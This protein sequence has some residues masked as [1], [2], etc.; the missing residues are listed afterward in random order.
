MDGYEFGWIPL[1]DPD[2]E[3]GRELVVVAGPQPGA[4]TVITQE[5]AARFVSVHQQLLH[6]EARASA[7]EHLL[8]NVP[9]V[10]PASLDH[11]DERGVVRVGSRVEAGDMLVGKVRVD[12]LGTHF[13]AS[14]RVSPHA[15]GTVSRA[16][17]ETLDNGSRVRVTVEL[18]QL[19]SLAIGDVLATA[20]ETRCVV[21]EIGGSLGGAD[22]R[23][24]GVAGR[25]RVGKLACADARLH[26]RS[27]GPYSL[28]TQRPIN[29]GQRV[30]EA[31][32]CALQARGAWWTAAELL[33]VK[34]GDITG[35]ENL[36]NSVVAGTPRCESTV[37][38]LVDALW[39]ELEAMGF[40]VTSVGTTERSKLQCDDRLRISLRTSNEIR[41]RSYGQVKYQ[42][43]VDN[44]THQPVPDGLFCERIFGP[45]ADFRC[46]C[47]ERAET[48]PRGSRCLQCGV[49]RI[50]SRAR[51]ERFGHIVL[52]SPVLH[53][54]MRGAVALLL[55]VGKSVIDDV[56]D[57]GKTLQGTDAMVAAE[58][59][60]SALGA[61][62]SA[63]NLASLAYEAGP[64][65]DLARAMQAGGTSPGALVLDVW[66]V[67]PPDL[68]PLVLLDGGR[69][70]TSDVT[71]L[72]LTL[73]RDNQRLDRMRALGT[74]PEEMVFFAER[75]LQYTVDALVQN[76]VSENSVWDEDA[77][78]GRLLVSLL[79]LS[80]DHFR[81]N[82]RGRT[83]DY[84]GTAVAV[85]VSSVGDDR[86]RLPRIMARE[87]FK[88]WI[89][90]E[91]GRRRL[92]STL[93]EA[94]AMVSARQ[95][96]AEAILARLV[97]G[98][99]VAVFPHRPEEIQP[100]I[101]VV[102][103]LVE[104]W[105]QPAVGISSS[106]AEALGIR[107]DGDAVVVHVPVDLRAV[108]EMLDLGSTAPPAAPSTGVLH[109]R[110]W[111][112]VVRIEACGSSHEGIASCVAVGAPCA[113]CSGMPVGTAIGLRAA[114]ALAPYEQSVLAAKTVSELGAL[115]ADPRYVATAF[116]QYPVGW[117]RRAALA[118]D[119]AIGPDGNLRQALGALVDVLVEAA[120]H[121]EVD[122]VD[123]PMTRSLVG[124]IGYGRAPL[125]EA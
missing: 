1:L 23:W 125:V 6:V 7:G 88:P 4:G 19:R 11:L 52:A 56:L 69:W 83:V 82:L 66:P 121:G 43:T 78:P 107:F 80:R 45:I 93:K 109:R 91:L 41:S 77:A 100:P 18:T 16:D 53:P 8:K 20:K 112:F 118:A 38:A 51:R 55:G 74:A 75:A 68:R 9:G 62:L 3:P 90:C 44:R 40:A 17:F 76:G 28:V 86:I 104:L 63:V 96:E 79:S 24:P 36:Y 34:S 117:L 26:G 42:R 49:E 15:R 33:T 120:L 124:R 110:L 98:Y 64:R 111:P 29:G 5:A 102:A 37:P 116:R 27:I 60:A 95:S 115:P 35:R 10:A 59:N 39:C 46:A 21:S 97:E 106:V 13:D 30:S 113:S 22:L 119:R 61:A 73:L 84:S 14:L 67:L 72:Y 57:N 31:E 81:A 48:G 70:A 92:I 65:G 32:I 103:L 114:D 47:G 101:P 108:R 122:E 58:T 87:I 99:P 50:H 94:K 89:F 2:D 71:D 54:C 12:P 105:D 25:L 85:P 123:D